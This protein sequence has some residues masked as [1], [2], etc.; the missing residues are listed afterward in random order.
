MKDPSLPEEKLLALIK[1][2]DPFGTGSPV[3]RQKLTS[4]AK[5]AAATSNGEEDKLFSKIVFI[6]LTLFLSLAF[7]M[8]SP[9]IM[10]KIN[11]KLPP[12][13][14]L[15]ILDFKD[16]GFIKG[17]YKNVFYRKA[18]SVLPVQ[19]PSPKKPPQVQDPLPS[20]KP[21]QQGPVPPA[22]DLLLPE[23]LLLAGIISGE[24][25]SA[26]IENKK[27]G[28]VV[29]VEPGNRIFGYVITGIEKGKVT[30]KKEN[31]EFILKL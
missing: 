28:E 2:A 9:L 11:I 29:T 24:N 31:Q 10:E 19:P 8:F 4:S 25:P 3:S 26:M 7:Y 27:S 30:L 21:N 6:L 14:A 15:R 22:G 5:R 1:E 18:D 23:D 17:L 20:M 16:S 12:E 13:I